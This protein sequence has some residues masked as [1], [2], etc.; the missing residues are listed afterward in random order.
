MESSILANELLSGS[1]SPRALLR[2][3]LEPGVRVLTTPDYWMRIPPSV[4]AMWRNTACQHKSVIV[5]THR[6]SL[7]EFRGSTKVRRCSTGGRW[8]KSSDI[9]GLDLEK[10][11]ASG[12]V[13]RAYVPQRGSTKFNQP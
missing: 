10:L 9:V 2:R 7:S 13:W 11:L 12:Y 1:E 3:L 6:P 8:G 5:C 4:Q